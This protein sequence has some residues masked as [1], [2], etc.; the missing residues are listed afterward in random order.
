MQRR[1]QER[2]D[3]DWINSIPMHG[4]DTTIHVNS[5]LALPEIAR[6]IADVVGGTL[7]GW[8]VKVGT[9]EIDVIAYDERPRGEVALEDAF[10]FYPYLVEIE[11]VDPEASTAAQVGAVVAIMRALDGLGAEYVTTADFE[12]ELPHHG[13]TSPTGS[14]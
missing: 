14:A 4:V 1:R 10:L 6:G 11:W 5:D 9:Y 3:S 12:D 13:R 7:S 2:R 8:T